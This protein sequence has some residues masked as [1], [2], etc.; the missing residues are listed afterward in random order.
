MSKPIG[1]SAS[2]W[3]V[4]AVAVLAAAAHSLA[5]LPPPAT[6]GSPAPSSAAVSSAAAPVPS[7]DPAASLPRYAP[8]VA[9]RT[10][11]FP[12]D[13]GSHPEFRIEWW[14]VTG[15]LTTSRGETLGFQITFFRTK[16]SI[17]ER[18]PSAFAPRQLL[19]AHCAVSDPAHGRPWHEQ[20]IQRAGFELAEA[21]PGDTHVWIG[22]WS[23]RRVASGGGTGGLYEASI[24]ADELAL[25]LEL[26]S[27]EPLLING[28]AG[29][30]RKGPARDAAS[31]YYSEPHLEVT[32]TVRRGPGSEEAV[33]GEAWLDHEWTSEY[34]AS[35]AVGWDWVG[36][37]L[38]DGGALMAFRIRRA[39]GGALWA[40][41][42]LRDA[43]GRTQHL[44]PGDVDFTPGRLWRSVHTATVY[45]V[46]WRLRAA[47]RDLELEPLMD[48]QEN[49]TRL[50]TGAVYWEGAVR[51]YESR[52]LLGRGYLELTGYS[53][54]LRLR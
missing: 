28:D 13:F 41:G 44:S 25:H 36:I 50:T 3:V 42:T 34:L 16:P 29:F 43:A 35:D 27:T 54:R 31:Y 2:P 51:A 30:S 20:R 39:D 46:T 1:R 11:H 15:W 38:N 24:D 22:H 18:N 10:L 19:I 37:N 14:Y 49:D 40:G 48:D 8:V 4:A 26:E 47:D 23:L 52:R 53:E 21:E 6:A 33:N 32:G 9:G 45:P 7:A 5:V 12:E 17:D